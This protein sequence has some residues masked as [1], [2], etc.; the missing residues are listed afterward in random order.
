MLQRLIKKAYKWACEGPTKYYYANGDEIITIGHQMLLD[1]VIL[2]NT[3]METSVAIVP[4]TYYMHSEPGLQDKVSMSRNGNL[5]VEQIPTP[6]ITIAMQYDEAAQAFIYG[7][8]ICSPEDN[9]VHKFGN[10]LALKRLNEG[11]GKIPYVANK[12]ISIKDRAIKFMEVLMASIE[13]DIVRY[14]R[15][16]EIFRKVGPAVIV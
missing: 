4:K 5:W 10:N 16:L 15:K 2:N 7:I 13:G 1:L 9:Y 8:S 12:P 11:F 6:R 14:Q 3:N